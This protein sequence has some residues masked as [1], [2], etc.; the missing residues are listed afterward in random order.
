MNWE[1]T[2]AF[3]VSLIRALRT[4]MQAG[5]GVIVAAQSGWL[6][7][8]VLEGALVAAGA[9]SAQRP[10]TVLNGGIRHGVLAMESYVFGLQLELE[11]LEN[12][13]A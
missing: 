9:A 3:K 5:V 8:S 10:V 12:E 1:L 11:V 2:D 7:M 13:H 6:E 4:G